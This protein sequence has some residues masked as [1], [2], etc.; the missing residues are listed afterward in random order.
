M[1]MI[2]LRPSYPMARLTRMYVVDLI[3]CIMGLFSAIINYTLSIRCSS[4]I[5]RYCDDDLCINLK[6]SLIITLSLSVIHT[7]INMYYV[8][9]EERRAILRSNADILNY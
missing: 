7:A 6:L 9:T 1:M 3:L 4:L 5:V 8:S 2:G